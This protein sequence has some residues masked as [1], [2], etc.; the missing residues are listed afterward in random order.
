[1]HWGI[2]NEQCSTR[3]RMRSQEPAWL[4]LHPVPANAY[5]W[6]PAGVLLVHL[7]HTCGQLE[8]AQE[9]GDARCA[10]P[11]PALPIHLLQLKG[12]VADLPANNR[13]PEKHKRHF[14]DPPETKGI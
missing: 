9:R 13:G 12:D 3:T 5:R 11:L 7:W 8:G 2:R 1:V 10:V 4:R 6:R 14:P